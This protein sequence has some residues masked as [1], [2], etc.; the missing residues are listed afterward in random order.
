MRR[1]FFLSD[2][3]TCLSIISR[4][5]AYATIVLAASGC[6]YNPPVERTPDGFD[7]PFNIY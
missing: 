6:A 3:L 7:P 4:W 5:V 1:V 2:D